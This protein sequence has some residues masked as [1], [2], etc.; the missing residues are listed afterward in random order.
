MRRH[1]LKTLLV[2]PVYNHNATLGIVTRRAIAAG[3][4]V[5]VVDDGS[6]EDVIVPLAGLSCRLLMIPENRGKGA[7]ILAGAMVAEEQGYDAIVTVDA[8]GQHDPAH[9]RALLR[10]TGEQWPVMVI[11]HR[12]MGDSTPRSSRFGRA[13][14]NFW[15]HLET[16][17]SLPDTQSGMR[18]Y[19]VREL[20][21][22][23]TSRTRYDF[24]IEVLVRGAWA[25]IPI[26][27][28]EVPVYYPPGDLCISH[29]NKWRDNLRLTRL[30]TRLICRALIPRAHRKLSCTPE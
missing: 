4:D 24:E 14:S 16:G 22:L 29:F 2:I 15:V 1:L 11:G 10:E 23:E 30:H 25:G 6:T 3:W 18:L 19:P 28:V 9:A 21:R 27:S 8:D 7:A 20:L 13:F 26:R 17:L 5:L 12:K